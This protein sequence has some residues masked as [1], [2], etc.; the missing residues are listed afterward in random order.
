[1]P[2]KQLLTWATGQVEDS[3]RQKFGIRAG[4]E[5]GLPGS[6][7]SRMVKKLVRAGL[8]LI[9]SDVTISERGGCANPACSHPR[10]PSSGLL[11]T[12]E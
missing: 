1:M 6:V 5:P 7:G 4:G 11:S 8:T 3:L 9:R 2:W 10:L 12:H